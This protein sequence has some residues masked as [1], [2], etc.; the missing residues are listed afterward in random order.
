MYYIFVAIIAFVLFVLFLKA[1]GTVV[2]SIVTTLFVIV[3]L[4]AGWLMYKSLESSVT[5][6]GRYKIDRFVVTRVT[7]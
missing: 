6:F 3:V 5:V 7:K 4:I 2:K 1:L